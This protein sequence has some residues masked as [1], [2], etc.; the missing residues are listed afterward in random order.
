ME[1]LQGACKKVSLPVVP[2]VP[3]G[4]TEVPQGAVEPAEPVALQ[5]PSERLSWEQAVANE[6]NSLVIDIVIGGLSK[7][8]QHIY[9]EQLDLVRLKKG[10]KDWTDNSNHNYAGGVGQV[11]S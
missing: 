7:L 3:D 10:E 9:D 8:G 11:I 6:L 5:G 4:V 2:P 1:V